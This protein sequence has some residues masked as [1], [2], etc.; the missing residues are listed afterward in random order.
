MGNPKLKGQRVPGGQSFNLAARKLVAGRR[1]SPA[2]K[3]LHHTRPS[4]LLLRTS[5]WLVTDNLA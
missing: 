2:Q 5:G 1:T 3:L 4:A